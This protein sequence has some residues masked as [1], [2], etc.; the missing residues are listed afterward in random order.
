MPASTRAAP[1]R[2]SS[3]L[4]LPLNDKERRR[5]TGAAPTTKS[6]IVREYVVAWHLTPLR[7]VSGPRNQGKGGGY[8]GRNRENGDY[9]TPDQSGEA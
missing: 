5:V 4:F 7:M 2:K 8:E 9:R 6:T 3:R 1:P